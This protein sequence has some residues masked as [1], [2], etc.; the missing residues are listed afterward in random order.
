MTI[1]SLV[2]LQELPWV[3]ATLYFSYCIHLQNP[4]QNDNMWYSILLNYGWLV[5]QLVCHLWLFLTFL[6]LWSK[7]S[8]I[9]KY[10][11]NETYVFRHTHTKHESE[12][13]NVRDAC[14]D[15]QKYTQLESESMQAWE[16][17]SVRIC[18]SERIKRWE[19]AN[20]DLSMCLCVSVLWARDWWQ[21]ASDQNL[22]FII[23]AIGHSS[24]VRM[25]AWVR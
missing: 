16:C 23:H 22:L 3:C 10:F 5:C 17:T 4:G 1:S 7:M 18:K 8:T 15:T 21:S 24:N 19:F 2:W 6:D 11:M 20:V 9:S 25:E 14:T 12:R 13:A